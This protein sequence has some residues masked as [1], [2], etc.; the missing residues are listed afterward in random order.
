MS[1]GQILK[2]LKGLRFNRWSVLELTD[3]KYTPSGQRK[4]HWL[5]KCDC[6]TIKS[7]YA[8]SLLSGKSISCGC[9]KRKLPKG[10]S[11][12]RA[13]YNGYRTKAN[14]IGL[15]F[16][17]SEKDFIKLSQLNCFYC[18]KAPSNF[19]SGYKRYGGFTYN[20]IDRINNKLG[21]IADNIISCCKNCNLAKRELTQDEFFDMIKRIFERHLNGKN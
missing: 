21:Y 14:R 12:M 3:F 5:C 6:G 20:G 7:V 4:T 13:I 2:D 9:A 8:D 19:Y 1:K 15:E 17:M 18:N 16:K 11:A 10:E